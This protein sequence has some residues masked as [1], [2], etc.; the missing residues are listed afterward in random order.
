MGFFSDVFEFD[1]FALKDAWDQIRDDPSRLITGVD[2]A[3][4]GIWNMIT[5]RDKEPIFNVFGG[6]MGGGGLGLRNEG[7]V[8][9]RAREA[10]FT[11]EQL[12]NAGIMHDVAE[13]V[14]SYYAGGALSQG[15]GNIGQAQGWNPYVTQGVQQGASQLT[16]MGES[17]ARGSPGSPN[18]EPIEDVDPRRD[19]M[20][21][22]R[23]RPTFAQPR[24]RRKRRKKYSTF[25][26]QTARVRPLPVETPPPRIERRGTFA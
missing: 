3:S 2:P 24:P 12:R 25:A 16:G 22:L 11:D 5:G 19:D 23:S 18:G 4:T 21:G 9:D 15:I 7:G 20:R 26:P 13:T 6:P 8:Y 1:K 17:Y 10:G 14:A